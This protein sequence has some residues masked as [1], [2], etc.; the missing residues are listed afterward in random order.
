MFEVT[1][2][3]SSYIFVRWRQ[4]GETYRFLVG[5]DGTLATDE[6]G[7]VQ[8]DARRMAMAYLAQCARP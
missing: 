4:T 5:Y 2:Y 7:S 1:K 3:E 8:G 6:I